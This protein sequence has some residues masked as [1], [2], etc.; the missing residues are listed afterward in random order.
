MPIQVRGYV[1]DRQAPQGLVT[2]V[3]CAVVRDRTIL[4]VANRGGEHVLPGGGVEAGET[5]EQ[6]VRR[7][8]FEETAWAVGPLRYLGFLY[9]KHQAAKPPGYRFPHPH[10]FQPVYCAPALSR[11][12]ERRIADDYETNC[13][14]VPF[15]EAAALEVDGVSRF[16]CDLVRR[17]A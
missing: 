10:F 14:F 4:V 11:H 2:S 15:A 12:L 5:Q 16:F 7:E 13:R 6:A 9:L 17:Q 3:R 1:T 8:L